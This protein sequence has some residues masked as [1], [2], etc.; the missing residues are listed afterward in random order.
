VTAARW[1]LYLQLV[2]PSACNLGE[3]PSWDGAA[4]KLLFV[5]IN[6]M[7]IYIWDNCSTGE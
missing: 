2:T 3:S 4:Q 7:T 6:G 5:D 1:R